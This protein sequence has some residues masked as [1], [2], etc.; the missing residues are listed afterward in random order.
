MTLCP[1]HPWR[2]RLRLR[3]RRGPVDQ[4]AAQQK[5]EGLAIGVRP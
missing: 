3:L 4:V 1:A 2:L 5:P